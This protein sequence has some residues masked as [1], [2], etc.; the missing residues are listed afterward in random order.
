MITDIHPRR[1]VGRVPRH[2]R[3]ALPVQLVLVAI[4]L[5]AGC[6]IQPSQTSEVGEPPT[7][8]AAGPV[9]Y[10]LDNDGE[11]VAQQREAGRLGTIAEALTLLLLGPGTSEVRTGI[12]DVDVTRV[13]VTVSDDVIDLRT[14]LAPRDLTESGYDQIVCTALAVHIQRG[15]DREIRVRVGLTQPSPGSDSLRTCPVLD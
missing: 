4:M 2:R 6:G 7:G 5:F 8:V 13:G 14:P 11:L 12:A 15:G 1:T 10:F 3:W 9:L